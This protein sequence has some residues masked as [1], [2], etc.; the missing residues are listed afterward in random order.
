MSD[1]VSCGS[2]GS[3]GSCDCFGNSGGG[4]GCCDDAGDSG[5]YGGTTA[6]DVVVDVLETALE[7]GT[8]AYLPV[9]TNTSR[10]RPEDADA[11]IDTDPCY[12]SDTCKCVTVCTLL[13][14]GLS[15]LGE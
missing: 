15:I 1:T 4:G 3:C 13:F 2:C 6:A 11:E 8:D 9:P 12:N 7:I 14:S 5:A 10:K